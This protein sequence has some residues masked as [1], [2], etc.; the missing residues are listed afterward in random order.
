M[1]YYESVFI[2][3]QD[4]TTPQVEALATEFAEIV[5]KSGGEVTKTE[6]WGLRNLAYR[7]KKNR[8]G[9][10]V[11]FNIDGP[12]AAIQELER[13]LRL[14]EDVLRYL[15]V[16]VEELEAGP[17]AIMR[18]DERDGERGERFDRSGPPRRDGSGRPPRHDHS[19]SDTP[20]E[21]RA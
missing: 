2:A 3:R 12:S 10:Y 20:E 6:Q 18:R 16:A 13:N 1:P 15:T 9:H 7:I 8:K 14:H 19:A 11:L 4:I 5:R 17:S 21:N